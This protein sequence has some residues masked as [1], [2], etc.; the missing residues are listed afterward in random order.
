M[1]VFGVDGALAVGALDGVVAPR[2][3]IPS[4]LLHRDGAVLDA[5]D[6]RVPIRPRADDVQLRALGVLEVVQVGEAAVRERPAVVTEAHVG[7]A[8][9]RRAS[10][11]RELAVDVE[12]ARGER[13]RRLRLPDVLAGVVERPPSDW[14]ATGDHR[15]SARRGS[16]RDGVSV[17]PR[18]GRGEHER[19]RESIGAV[20]ELDR[21]IAGQRAV[22]AT[23][24]ELCLSER[25][26]R[27]DVARS[28]GAAR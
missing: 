25:T 8:D 14:R 21:E 22:H 20:G 24:D 2:V 10:A 6:R 9:R 7:A 1:I 11:G 5:L 19:R 4:R 15:V 13:A 23:H 3:L 12:L 28:A 17:R 27:V 18:V 16:P 26:G